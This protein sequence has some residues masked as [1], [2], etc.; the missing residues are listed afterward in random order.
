VY[1]QLFAGK[2]GV[3]EEIDYPTTAQVQPYTYVTPGLPDGN[4]FE[5]DLFPAIGVNIIQ[6]FGAHMDIGG[7]SYN[8]YNATDGQS[9]NMHHFNI[10][11][12]QQF[13]VG[14][15]KIIGWKKFNAAAPKQPAMAQ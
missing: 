7:I 12:G 2:Y 8:T 3:N 1:T 5:V 11:F 9:P 14:I 13:S 10:T 4:G 15:H 6:G